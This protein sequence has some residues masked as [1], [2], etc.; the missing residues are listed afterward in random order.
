MIYFVLGCTFIHWLSKCLV[1]VSCSW[2]NTLISLIN[3][4]PTLT[5]FEK[6]HPQQKNPPST[7]IDSSSPRLLKLCISFF[8]KIPPSKFIPTSTFSD[9]ANFAPPQGLFQPP[10]LLERWEYAYVPAGRNERGWVATSTSFAVFDSYELL[11]W[12]SLWYLQRPKMPRLFSRGYVYCF[13][14]MFQWLRL[15]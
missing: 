6:F 1:W 4:G 10:R 12:I 2:S 13:P 8:H 5:D 11:I 15:F 9:L 3:V 14:Q 7:F